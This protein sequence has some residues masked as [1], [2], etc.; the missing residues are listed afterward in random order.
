MSKEKIVLI[1]AG[2]IINSRSQET[3]L[4]NSMIEL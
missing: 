3:Q 2:L 4:L 1:G